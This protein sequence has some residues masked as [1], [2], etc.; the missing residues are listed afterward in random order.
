MKPIKLELQ[1]FGPY[2][3]YELIDFETLSNN[4]LFLICGETGSGKTMILDAMTYALYGSDKGDARADLEAL[5]CNQSDFGIDTFVKFTFKNHGIIYVFEKKLICKK[6]NFSKSQNV[7]RIDD[8]N[9]ETLFENGKDREI[10][11]F[12]TE[13]IGLNKDQFRQVIILPQGKFEKLLTSNSNEKQEILSNIFGTKKWESVANIFFKNAETQRA[14]YKNLK[15]RINSSIGQYDCDDIEMF[16][17]KVED[18]EKELENLENE[19]HKNN[20]SNQLEKLNEQKQLAEKFAELDKQIN[21]LENYHKLDNEIKNDEEKL[22]KATKVSAIEGEINDYQNSETQLKSRQKDFEKIQKEDL[23]NSEKKFEL[24][25]KN[26][27]EHTNKSNEI[28]KLKEKKIRLESKKDIYESINTAFNKLKSAEELYEQE[29]K[30]EVSAQKNFKDLK[31]KADKLKSEYEKLN[32][33]HTEQFKIYNDGICGELASELEDGKPCPVCGSLSHPNKAH[34]IDGAI[35]R[36]ELDELKGNVDEKYSKWSDADED[37]Q[38]AS[39]ELDL[40]KDKTKV[41]EN[42]KISARVEYKA[43]ENNKVDNI[44]SL[45]D[46]NNSI[47]VIDINIADY[48]RILD[49]LSKTYDEKK[50]DFEENKTKLE[51]AQ[52][53]LNDVKDQFSSSEKRLLSSLKE[54]GFENIDDAKQYI[55]DSSTQQ[56]L[57][58]KITTHKNNI[59][60]C[61]EEIEN[62]KKSIDGKNPQDIKEVEKL[63]EEIN[64]KIA[65]YN[66]NHGELKERLKNLSKV[67]ETVDKL[68]EEYEKGFQQADDDYTFA[69]AVRG[70]TGIGLQRYVLAVMFSKVISEANRMLE[71]VHGGRYHL[72]RTDDK[73]T[74]SNKRGLEL[75]VHDSYS[76]DKDGRSVNLLSGGEKFLVSLSLA[77]G[78]S[79][80]A[81]KSGVKIEAMFIDEG[82]GTLDSNSIDDAMTILSSIQKANGMVG[83][84]S[85]V[86]VLRDNIPTKLEVIKSNKGSSIKSIVG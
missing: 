33:K 64:I 13:L 78:M 41:A 12:A 43:I 65:D 71:N 61:E 58:R 40:Q 14:Y 2:K 59:E 85:H 25:E 42:N 21:K 76:P 77:I 83:I 82:F 18:V 19:Y 57:Q 23:P 50:S 8:G 9:K 81:Q 4:G 63:I 79:T 60:Y 84:I 48:G 20:Y 39:R 51:T 52:N 10:T 44:N 11:E 67:K 6:K 28:E 24:A 1:A 17:K 80:V 15:D 34:R 36:A 31:E 55:L 66:E 26:L 75:K 38:K 69:K 3:G 5:R 16:Y 86:Q 72:F 35:T 45:D 62:L 30:N 70:D 73:G 47:K 46:L 68:N 7:F 74:G 27:T 49:G 53:E 22:K 37:V 29:Q 54:Q 32:D 56:E